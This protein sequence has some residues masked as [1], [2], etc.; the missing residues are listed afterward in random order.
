MAKTV[1]QA[2]EDMDMWEQN[3]HLSVRHQLDPGPPQLDAGTER[4]ARR[5]DMDRD[6][7]HT[8]A[9]RKDDQP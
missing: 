4:H 9:E 2:F 5:H 1:I 8:H 6:I 7:D 3:F